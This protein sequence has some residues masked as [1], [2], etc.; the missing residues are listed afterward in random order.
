MMQIE[1]GSVTEKS[2]HSVVNKPGGT[3]TQLLG[4]KSEFRL[5]PSPKLFLATVSQ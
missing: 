3:M 4:S 5:R 2:L 1:N